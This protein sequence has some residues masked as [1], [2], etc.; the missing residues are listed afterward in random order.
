MGLEPPLPGDLPPPPPPPSRAALNMPPMS[1]LAPTPPAP[2]P[3]GAAPTPGMSRPPIPLPKVTPPKGLNM[4]VTG[5]GVRKIGGK[6]VVKPKGDRPTAVLRKRP[7]LSLFAKIGIGFAAVGILVGAFF[8]YRIFFQESNQTVRIPPP[9]VKKPDHPKDIEKSAAELVAKEASTATVQSAPSQNASVVVA[10]RQAQQQAK[11]GEAQAKPPGDEAA[12]AV[13]PTPEVEQSVMADS[14]LTSEVKVNNQQIT[15]VPTASAQFKA[16]VAD[17][18]IGGV[19]Q[20]TPSRAL[21]NGAI[22]REGQTV[23]N[24]MGITFE[25]IDAAEKVIYFKDSTGA[26]VSKNY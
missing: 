5:D 14:S 25:R 2:S 9:I 20:G 3:E 4:K 7:A 1:V 6:P 16:W 11:A 10:K 13:T 18:S 17:A 19:F 15:A 24:A 26:R 21:I 12:S 22:V 23:Q 8:S